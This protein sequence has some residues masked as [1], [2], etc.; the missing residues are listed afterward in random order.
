MDI[1]YILLNGLAYGLC[2]GA[3]CQAVI[4]A[5]DSATHSR[6]NR[7]HQAVVEAYMLV[8]IMLLLAIAI[9]VSMP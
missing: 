6:T 9:K 7:T 4:V 3:T 8:M 5:I 2:I 1:F